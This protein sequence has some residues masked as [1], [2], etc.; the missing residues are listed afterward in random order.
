MPSRRSS[1]MITALAGTSR[2]QPCP[3]EVPMRPARFIS[4]LT[5]LL[6]L[7]LVQSAQAPAADRSR[8]HF[9]SVAP[10]RGT[11]PSTPD[12]GWL[13]AAQTDITRAEYRFSVDSGGALTAP[14]RSQDLRFRI[15][16]G[17][18]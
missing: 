9:P 3:G 11:A 13:S 4:A 8:E 2:L 10:A 16:A 15:D 17:G 14:S 5:A 12:A 1:G 7:T 18:V 6:I